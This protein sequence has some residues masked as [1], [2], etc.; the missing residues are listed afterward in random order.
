MRQ[1]TTGTETARRGTVT[2]ADRRTLAFEVMGAQHPGEPVLLLRPLGGSMPLWGRFRERLAERARVIAFD[3]AGAGESSA[4]PLLIGTR[5]RAWDAAELL[6][7]LGIGRAHVFGVSL[8]G[9]VATWLAV[10]FPG[11]VARLCLASTPPAGL[12]LSAS[13]LGRGLSLATCLARPSREVQPCLV[14]R[15][16]SR[17]VREGDPG[18]AGH[19]AA[20]AAG[21]PARRRELLKQAAAAMLHDARDDLHRVRAPTLVLAGDQD[22]LLGAGPQRELAAA[23]PGARFELVPEAGHALT[24]EQPDRVA[25]LVAAFFFG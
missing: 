23:I 10:E 24:L 20:A 7:E 19:I 3:H 16:L 18:R 8:G 2:L 22:E 5:G 11:R 6:D 9:M 25:D 14:R 15:V 4:A 1:D 12:D 13:G 21:Q 17:A